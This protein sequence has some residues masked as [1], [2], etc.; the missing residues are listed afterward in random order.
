M[1]KSIGAGTLQNYFINQLIQELHVN[2]SLMER[3]S[4]DPK[5]RSKNHQ[6]MY[7]ECFKRDTQLRKRLNRWMS[8]RE[9][10]TDA[11][12]QVYM[13]NDMR[14]LDS[15][16]D[17]ERE[18]IESLI[19]IR[20][21]DPNNQP[22]MTHGN[23]HDYNH[24]YNGDAIDKGKQYQHQHHQSH[25]NGNQQSYH[26]QEQSKPHTL[27]PLR[28]LYNEKNNDDTADNDNDDRNDTDNDKDTD[29]ASEKKDNNNNTV[30]G[31]PDLDNLL[32]DIELD[33]D[34][35]KVG[36]GGGSDIINTSS[37]EIEV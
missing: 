18:K 8:E 23:N 14:W 11:A 29:T 31:D 26:N 19:A 36:D 21:H 25:M 4:T 2:Y 6:V 3:I 12:V 30:Q 32:N 20:T 34:D 16:T 22:P 9:K 17:K 5:C 10:A 7:D 35:D 27:K 1:T 28:S 33:A 15:L 37:G 13:S 24:H